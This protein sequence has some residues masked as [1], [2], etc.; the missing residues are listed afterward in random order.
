VTDG[1]TQAYV[2]TYFKEQLGR[3]V[4]AAKARQGRIALI[5]VDIDHFKNV[6]DKHGHRA[7][8]VVL[9]G[10]AALLRRAVRANDLVAR[11]GGE[12]FALVLSD[13]PSR[14][15][16]AVAE[17]LRKAVENTVFPCDGVPIWITA[18]FGVAVLPFDADSA[19]SLIKVSDEFLYAS[20]RGGRNRVTCSDQVRVTAE[21]EQSVAFPAK[22]QQ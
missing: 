19:D 21:R 4:E 1:L 22:P 10:V 2:Q 12:E 11:Y 16:L 7:G 14:I 15:V 17:R 5:M 8:D 6:N 9:Q 3:L 13:V 20:K 18:S